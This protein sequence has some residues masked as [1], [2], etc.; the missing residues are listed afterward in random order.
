MSATVSSKTIVQK[1]FDVLY[2]EIKFKGIELPDD[3]KYLISELEEMLLYKLQ[4]Y[5][6]QQEWQQEVD[7]AY[8]NG[9]DYGYEAGYMEGRD[10]QLANEDE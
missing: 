1:E 2:N 9:Y 7:D 3:M 6:N 4:P 5:L 10:E 8:D